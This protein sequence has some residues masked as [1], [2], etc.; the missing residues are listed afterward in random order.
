MEA[1]EELLMIVTSPKSTTPVPE[2]IERTHF[3]PTN[4]DFLT[5]SMMR[6]GF[7]GR[8]RRSQS[9]NDSYLIS[10]F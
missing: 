6:G 5:L 7:A 4:N 9:L 2:P 3:V 1:Q 8:R 10:A